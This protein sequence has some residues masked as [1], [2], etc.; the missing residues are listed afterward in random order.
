MRAE[1]GAEVKEWAPPTY[2]SSRPNYP[3]RDQCVTAIADQIGALHHPRDKTYVSTMDAT[4]AR[5][6][7]WKRT[8]FAEIGAN[9][10]LLVDAEL[11]T[12][13]VTFDGETALAKALDQFQLDDPA[14]LLST[15]RS[16]TIGRDGLNVTVTTPKTV[17]ITT[18]VPGTPDAPTGD[19]LLVRSGHS[20][21]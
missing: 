20:G 15:S 6:L 19:P 7:R 4:L 17:T 10:E 9:G 5:R 21:L 12:D 1:Y 14:N 8:A 18:A 13:V 3:S 2:R 11:A 16:T